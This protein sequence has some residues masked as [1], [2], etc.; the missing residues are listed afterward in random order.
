MLEL[1]CCRSLLLLQTV[2]NDNQWPFASVLGMTTTTTMS[3]TGSEPRCIVISVAN[4]SPVAGSCPRPSSP[5]G[6]GETAS[7]AAKERK[8]VGF[9]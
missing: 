1:V 5:G 7:V 8:E 2:K 4:S 6:K 9:R 3:S